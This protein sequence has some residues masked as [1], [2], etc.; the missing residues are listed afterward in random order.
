[1]V[2][3]HLFLYVH[4][5]DHPKTIFIGQDIAMGKAINVV[6]IEAWHG[7]CNFHIKQKTLNSQE[8]YEDSPN[9]LAKFSAC[10]YKY[11][12]EET[13]EES[14]TDIRSKVVHKPRWT[15]YIK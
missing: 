8:K 7:L 6:F 14:F 9:I 5:K 3:Q 11:E 10:M 4:N 12:E 1:M 15:S 13:F 2:V